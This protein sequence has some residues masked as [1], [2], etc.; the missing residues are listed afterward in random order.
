MKPLDQ[1]ITALCKCRYIN[2]KGCPYRGSTGT[3]CKDQLLDDA[4]DWLTMYRREIEA[5]KKEQK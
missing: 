3:A 5:G 4:A 1:V 2:C